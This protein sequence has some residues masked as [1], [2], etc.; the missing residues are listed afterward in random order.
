MPNDFF[1]DGEGNHFLVKMQQRI[2]IYELFLS[3]IIFHFC[4]FNF[5]LFSPFFGLFSSVKRCLA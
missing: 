4:T 1:V 3:A 5:G 2:L